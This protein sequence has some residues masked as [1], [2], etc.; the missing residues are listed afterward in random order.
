MRVLMVGDVVGRPG[1]TAVTR[2]LPGLRTELELDYV[3]LNGENA[4]AGRGLT[5]K[6]AR[7]LLRAGVDV[8]TSGN[9]IYAVREFV[10]A[11]D[12]PRTTPHRPPA[13]GSSAPES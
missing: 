11:L 12:G 7:E 2:I 4:A 5:E 8:I 13:E 3:V 10:P 9:H 1:R 6:I